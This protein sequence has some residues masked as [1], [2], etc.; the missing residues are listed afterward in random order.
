M[1]KNLD[2]VSLYVSEIK[3]EMKPECESLLRHLCVKIDISQFIITGECCSLHYFF[4]FTSTT[5]AVFALRITEF[6]LVHIRVR[7]QIE[8]ELSLPSQG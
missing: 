5:L 3:W 7:E 2:T 4:F 1:S 8:L 6:S